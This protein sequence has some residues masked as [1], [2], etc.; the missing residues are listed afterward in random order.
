M[1]KQHNKTAMAIPAIAPRFSLSLVSVTKTIFLLLPGS[2]GGA[3][4]DIVAPDALFFWKLAIETCLVLVDGCC[5]KVVALTVVEEFGKLLI[6]I[7]GGKD[8]ET[9]TLVVEVVETGIVG[10]D[11][12][13]RDKTVG[14]NDFCFCAGGDGDGGGNGG[15]TEPEVIF[16]GGR[17]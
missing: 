11:G 12:G 5:V 8:G 13:G 2:L 16:T 15:E 6:C 7:K 9:C 3:L 10:T 14:K 1:R 4:V 17:E